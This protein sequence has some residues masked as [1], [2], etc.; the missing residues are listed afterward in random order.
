MLGDILLNS[1]IISSF[2]MIC[3]S[4]YDC[5][6]EMDVETELKTATLNQHFIMLDK[7]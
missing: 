4:T 3:D 6:A 2:F 5:S 1:Y 7:C